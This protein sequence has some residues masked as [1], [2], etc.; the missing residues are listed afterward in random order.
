MHAE[1]EEERMGTGS[2]KDRLN[3]EI[4]FTN[5]VHFVFELIL[6]IGG[7]NVLSRLSLNLSVT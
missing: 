2:A 5:K 1:N 7:E 6:R 3:R 4:P